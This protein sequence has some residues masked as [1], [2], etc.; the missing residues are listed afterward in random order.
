VIAKLIYKKLNM[1]RKYEGGP[2]YPDN[3]TKNSKNE[4]KV[5]VVIDKNYLGLEVNHFDLQSLNPKVDMLGNDKFT[6]VLFETQSGNMYLIYR[7]PDHT[8]AI[9]DAKSNTGK[10]LKQIKGSLLSDSEIANGVLEVGKNFH[11]GKGW[12]TSPISKITC[13]N[14]NKIYDETRI[15]EL[16][17][18]KNS[19]ARDKFKNRIKPKK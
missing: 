6:E 15:H 14:G 17:G 16:T 5:S 11:F 4:K 1:P 18:G 8:F 19:D 10:G 3:E 12:Q 2:Q 9:A 13:I 7:L